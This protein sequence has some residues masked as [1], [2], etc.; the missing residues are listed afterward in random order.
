[1]SPLP[2]SPTQLTLNY[3]LK[4][5]EE[6]K[7]TLDMNIFFCVGTINFLF[8]FF[9]L[10]YHVQFD[11]ELA[12]PNKKQMCDTAPPTEKNC[13]FLIFIGIFLEKNSENSLNI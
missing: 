9:N 6:N 7:L 13:K 5:T 10:R 2:Q 4:E 11:F 12:L 1:M 3:I 8:R